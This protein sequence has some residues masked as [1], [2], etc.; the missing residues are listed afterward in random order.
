[1]QERLSGS[2]ATYLYVISQRVVFLRLAA[3][4]EGWSIPLS[5]ILPVPIGIFR[6]MF[7]ARPTAVPSATP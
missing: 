7:A 3:L 4:Y 2:Q 6:A 1:V 5:A